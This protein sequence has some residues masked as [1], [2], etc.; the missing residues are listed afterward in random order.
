MKLQRYEEALAVYNQAIEI[1]F[2]CADYWYNKACCYA[3]QNN[4]TLAIQ[5]LQQSIKLESDG[6]ELAK[7]DPDFDAIR[8]HEMFKILFDEYS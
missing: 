4:V 6:L 5:N 2:D 3:L 7:T 8:E 1:K